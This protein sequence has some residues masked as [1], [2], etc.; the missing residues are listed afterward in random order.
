MLKAVVGSQKELARLRDARAVILH[1]E[2]PSLCAGLDF[3]WLLS[4]RGR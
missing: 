2:G 3:K 1:G 4:R